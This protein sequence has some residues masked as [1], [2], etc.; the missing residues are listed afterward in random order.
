M[1]NLNYNIIGSIGPIVDRQGAIF[2]VRNDPF[3][4]SI[5]LAVPGNLFRDGDYT[6]QFG[7][8]NAWDDISAYVRGGTNNAPIGNNVEILISSSLNPNSSSFSLSTEIVKWT[9]NKYDTSINMSGVNS[10]VA[11]ETWASGSGTNISYNSDF[12]IETWILFPNTASATTASFQ[13]DRILAWKYDPSSPGGSSYLWKMRGGDIDTG[14]GVTIVSGSQEWVYDF[15]LN[16]YYIFPTGSFN[17]TPY[18]W[19]HMAISYTLGFLGPGLEERTLK[20]Y[21]NGVKVRQEVIPPGIDINQ[22]LAELLQF[23]GAVDSSFVENGYS[24]SAIYLQDFRFYNGTDKNYTG[25]IIPL[26]ESIVVYG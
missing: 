1:L 6:N 4:S 11:N 3:S 26:P 5:V 24:G 2:S 17:I 10:L 25:S 13:P 23:G 20:M 12:L 18:Q 14:P 22:D 21:W 8:Q 7:M 19:N 15:G 9:S 16:E